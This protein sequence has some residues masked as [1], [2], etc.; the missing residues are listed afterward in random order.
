M[1]CY[2]S[3]LR[4]G[5]NTTITLLGQKYPLAW[6]SEKES[7]K[8]AILD[9]QNFVRIG[10]VAFN[11]STNIGDN[12]KNCPSLSHPQIPL[13]SS[14]KYLECENP[15]MQRGLVFPL[16]ERHFLFTFCPTNLMA[17]KVNCSR[18]EEEMLLMHGNKT[19]CKL[20]NMRP[21]ASFS[22]SFKPSSLPLSQPWLASPPS[23]SFSSLPPE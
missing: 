17:K 21:L 9:L 12:P 23:F 8:N 1:G 19:F 18:A 22:P 11:E 16:L 10:H 4:F 6:D 15:H 20:A 13:L 5:R 14:R 7:D 2:V 3:S